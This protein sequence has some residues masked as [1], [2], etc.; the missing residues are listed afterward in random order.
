MNSAKPHSFVKMSVWNLSVHFVQLLSY[1]CENLSLFQGKTEFD[2]KHS[3]LMESLVLF[4][5]GIWEKE[6]QNFV[7]KLFSG[8]QGLTMFCF[9]TYSNMN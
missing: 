9:G 4:P 2:R 6:Q 7:T 3:F 8:F 5:G 1:W